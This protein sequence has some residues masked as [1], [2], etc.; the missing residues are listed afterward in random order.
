MV[1]G[2]DI[3]LMIFD[4]FPPVADNRPTDSLWFHQLADQQPIANEL[5]DRD[6]ESAVVKLLAD[7]DGPLRL[8]M[9]PAPRQPHHAEREYL[10]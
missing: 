8:L 10:D 9:I 2:R 7:M 3:R 5:G 1:C 4:E 6:S